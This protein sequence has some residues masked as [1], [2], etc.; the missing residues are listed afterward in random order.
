MADGW[1][2]MIEGDDA[3]VAAEISA[4]KASYAFHR[5]AGN[6][7]S[8]TEIER[9]YGLHGLSPCQVLKE[10]GEMSLPIGGAA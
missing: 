1:D 8:C 5:H 2:T 4:D 7:A 9:K 6:V 3:E 10:L